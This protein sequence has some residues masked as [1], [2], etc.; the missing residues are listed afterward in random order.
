[1]AGLLPPRRR[2]VVAALGGRLITTAPIGP[3]LAD[4]RS[5]LILHFVEESHNVIE[6]WLELF[7]LLR[8]FQV[9]VLLLRLEVLGRF[10]QL[11]PLVES[12]D[13]FEGLAEGA[14]HL[15]VQ[16]LVVPFVLPDP[17]RDEL[18]CACLLDIIVQPR[19]VELIHAEA[20]EVEERLDVVDWTRIRIQT[21]LAHG[22][23]HGVSLEALD[24]VT[25]FPLDSL[26]QCEVDQVE[27]PI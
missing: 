12:V 24:T 1:M 13:V 19:Q 3:T 4:L 27:A 23:E 5:K 22:G 26:R 11:V 9:L 7:L 21:V 17:I 18:V 25:R 6:V 2:C 16:V 10:L 14:R 20:D 8:R 15:L